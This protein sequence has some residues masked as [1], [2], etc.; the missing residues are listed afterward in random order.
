MS[1]L[2]AAKIIAERLANRDW[3]AS[4]RPRPRKRGLK[5][6]ATTRTEDFRDLY[7]VTLQNAVPIRL[8]MVLISQIQRSGGTLLAQL[9]D[10]HSQCYAYAY[11]LYI[12]FPNKTVWPVLDLNESPTQWFLTLFET[13][14]SRAF[15]RGYQKVSPG[16]G[17]DGERFLFIFLPSLQREIFLQ[18]CKTTKI[19][20]QRDVFDAYMTSYFNAWLNHRGR[21]GQKKVITSFVERVSISEENVRRFFEVYPD[22]K[23][24][25]IIRNPWSWYDSA[26]RHNPNVFGDVERAMVLWKESAESMIRNKRHYGERVRIIQYEELIADTR[27]V[28]SALADYVGIDYDDVLL[29]PTF[30]TMPI[31]ADSSYPV[32]EYGVLTE[33]LLR[34]RQNLAGGDQKK[35]EQLARQTYESVID[36]I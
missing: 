2:E 23:L 16:S 32:N 15:R 11:E 33:P 1:V 6:W 28:M 27:G 26:R 14:V 13:P 9:F 3:I 8:P 21:F 20:S 24:L 34:Y 30:N 22:G 31:K 10:G 5:R 18:Y 19:A 12:G 17:Q 25:S 35:I 7:G 36:S 4:R 29:Q